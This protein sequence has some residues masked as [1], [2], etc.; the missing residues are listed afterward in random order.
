MDMLKIYRKA[1]LS[2]D[3]A[4]LIGK[5]LDEK[6]DRHVAK[7]LNGKYLYRTTVHDEEKWNVV[8]IKPDSNFYTESVQIFIYLERSDLSKRSK[9]SLKHVW[10]QLSK[11]EYDPFHK[12]NSGKRPVCTRIYFNI[13]I[14]EAITC[15]FQLSI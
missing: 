1:R 2:Y 5:S 7:Y 10:D 15:A 9:Q 6:I 13:S 14:Q 12:R 11:E 4:S 3:T 8:A